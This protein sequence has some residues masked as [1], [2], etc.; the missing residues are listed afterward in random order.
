MPGRG[1]PGHHLHSGPFARGTH[2][3]QK[4]LHSWLQLITVKGYRLNSTQGK[5]TGGQVQEKPTSCLILPAMT[6]NHSRKA[7]PAGGAHPGFGVQ[8]FY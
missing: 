1:S 5:G 6:H 7:L 3:T 2:N 8:G 4:L